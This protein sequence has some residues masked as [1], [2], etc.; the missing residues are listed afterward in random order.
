[1]STKDLLLELS[2]EEAAQLE[3]AAS[4]RGCT[5]EEWATACLITDLMCHRT[6]QGQPANDKL[7]QA[8]K[9]AEDRGDEAIR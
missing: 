4:E 3:L 9:P 1:M 6:V 5:V 2:R 8:K 7:E